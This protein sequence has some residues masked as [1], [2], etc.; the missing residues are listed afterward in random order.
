MYINLPDINGF[1][2]CKKIRENPQMAYIPIFSVFTQKRI[3]LAPAL[4]WH[5]YAG[6]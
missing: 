3:F 6:L 5:W 1:E 2:V 4:V